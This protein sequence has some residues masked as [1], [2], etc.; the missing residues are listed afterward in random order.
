MCKGTE[1]AHGKAFHLLQGEHTGQIEGHLSEDEEG[2]TPSVDPSIL[3]DTEDAWPSPVQTP[4]E[5]DLT[6]PADKGEGK[7][8][9]YPQWIRVH[10]SQKEATTGGEPGEC[11]PTLPGALSELAPW[12]KEEKGTDPMDAPGSS[13]APISLLEPSLRMVLSTLVG[14]CPS[15]G[16]VFMSTLT[17]SIEVK[18]LEAPSEVEGCQGAKVKELA[19]EEL[20]EGHPSV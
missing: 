4:L 20:A 16:T 12:D 11:G 9:V 5:E 3:M 8:Q 18:N 15:M 13:K 2:K 7:E 17:A 10:S 19:G 6:R 1:V 14:R